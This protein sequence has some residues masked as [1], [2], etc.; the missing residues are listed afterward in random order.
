VA[1]PSLIFGC[2]LV[3]LAGCSG[4]GSEP[5]KPF[6]ERPPEAFVDA[7]ARFCAVWERIRPDEP[8]VNGELAFHGVVYPEGEPTPDVE[9]PRSRDAECVNTCSE[10]TP[11]ADCWQ[12]TLHQVESMASGVWFCENEAWQVEIPELPTG[13]CER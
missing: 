10:G 3:L 11:A 4:R 2:L 13:L 12:E 1:S 6:R 9:P 5:A 8:C 7:C